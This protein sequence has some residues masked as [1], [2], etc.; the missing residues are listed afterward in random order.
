MLLDRNF[1]EAA[2]GGLG[3]EDVTFGVASVFDGLFFDFV[4]MVASAL[5]PS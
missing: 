5:E 3:D 1:L 4:N 2:S